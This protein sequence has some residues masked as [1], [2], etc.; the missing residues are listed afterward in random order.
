MNA[1][2]LGLLTVGLM[3]SLTACGLIGSSGPAI[4]SFSATPPTIMA[5]GSSTLTWT[6]DSS[7]TSVSISSVGDVTGDTSVTVTPSVTTEYTLTAENADGTSTRATTVTVSDDMGSGNGPGPIDPDPGD[8]A[9]APEGTF[10]V[11]TSADG[12]FTNDA[13]EE[14]P[15]T[16]DG[17]ARIISVPAGG[18]FYA[19]VDYTDPDGI[20]SITIQ[21]RNSSPEGISGPLPAGGFTV[22]EPTG[23]C[24]LGSATAVTC[25]YPITVDPTV[26]D[27]SELDGAGGEFAYVF[28]AQVTDAL[29]NAVTGQ[30]RG[31]VNID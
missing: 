16:D 20:A 21:L 13:G 12:T 4:S 9:S 10:G 18:T 17:D 23:T 2:K 29:G 22:G 27:I 30:E 15:I 6:V 28:R 31:Y 1:G 11:S 24:D 25:V 14:G 7:A 5:G 8:P 3:L 19:E 26:V